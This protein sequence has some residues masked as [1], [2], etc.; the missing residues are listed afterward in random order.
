[1]EAELEQIEEGRF[2]RRDEFLA[3]F[4]YVRSKILN[5]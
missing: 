4:D 3:N 2:E 1:M 5:Q